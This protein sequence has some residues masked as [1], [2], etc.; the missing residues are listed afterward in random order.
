MSEHY[1]HGFSEDEQRRLSA[2]QTLLNQRQLLAMDLGGVRRVLDVGSGL[3]QM[4]R[5]IAR[6]LGARQLVVG[7]EQNSEQLAEACRQAAQ[8]KEAGLVDFRPGSAYEL[9]ISAEEQGSFDLVHARFLLEHVR[10]PLRIVQQMARAVR[11]GGQVVLVDDDHDLLRLWPSC[12]PYER[13]WE[14]YW[15]SYSE[16]GCDPLVGRRLG[17]LL[18]EA[19]LERVAV[20]TIFYGAHTG[21]E[22]FGA[23][24][25]NLIGVIQS[26]AE[27]LDAQNLLSSN[28]WQRAREAL[29]QWRRSPVACV[30]YAL[31]MATAVRTR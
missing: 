5:A 20:Q 4:T 27:M 22:L 21:E 26:A 1:I 15:R 23:V 2:M 10:D 12:P 11:I 14:A 31:P 29:D 19:G 16:I 17:A 7:V 24:V 3:G 13:A 18:Y 9:P 6:A 25:D 8:A 28:D 30:W